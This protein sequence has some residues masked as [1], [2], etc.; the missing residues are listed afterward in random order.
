METSEN[1]AMRDGGKRFEISKWPKSFQVK[2]RM[3]REQN[4]RILKK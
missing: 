2:I 1:H 3:K 4:I